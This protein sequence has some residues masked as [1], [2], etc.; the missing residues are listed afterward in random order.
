M[1]ATSSTTVQ[2]LIGGR[3]NR[4]YKLSLVKRAKNWHYRFVCHK[5]IWSGDTGWAATERNRIP[6]SL[7]EAEQRRNVLLGKGGIT[8]IMPIPFAD[9]AVPFLADCE[10]KH[11][12]KPNTY[13][14]MRGSF[15]SLTVYF[16]NKLVSTMTRADTISYKNW[17]TNASDVKP[18]TIRHD[19]HALS[20]FFQYAEIQ[21]WS[22]GNPVHS[23]DIPSDKDAVRI[24][25]V[26]PEEERWYFAK[27]LKKNLPQLHDLGRLMLLMGPRPEELLAVEST[28]IDLF[29]AQLQ[30]VEGKS[31]AA[32]RSLKF[33]GECREIL[34]RLKGAAER[35][36]SRYIFHAERDLKLPLSLSTIETQQSKLD[37]PFVIYDLR[38]TFATRAV[39]DKI[40][41]WAL[42]KIMG[43]KDLRS[44]ARYVHL[45]QEDMD[46][47][48][49]ALHKTTASG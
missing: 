35:A 27:L 36:G 29:D 49:L 24:H 15:A 13:K 41:L 33:D 7:Y 14:R 6:A 43:H 3:K 17:R 4:K 9:A 19:M 44:I 48:M 21:R 45:N 26:T 31:A 39:R 5:R 42:V 12:N 32:K 38:H 22:G 46:A 2:H 25:P 10:V 47:A 1:V 30:I 20:K 8:K 28:H 34:T 37:A 23:D 16:S 18:V 11:A 40:N